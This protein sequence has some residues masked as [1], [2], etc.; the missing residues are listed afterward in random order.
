MAPGSSRAARSRRSGHRG[1]RGADLG[2]GRADDR[3]ARARHAE[4]VQAPDDAGNLV[5]LKT[6]GGEETSHSIVFAR[7]GLSPASGPHFQ[8][9]IML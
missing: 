1:L 3:V 4:L 6:G 5:E 8:L 9:T 2:L 7:H